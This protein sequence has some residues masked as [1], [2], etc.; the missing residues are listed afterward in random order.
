MEGTAQREAQIPSRAGVCA[1][2]AAAVHSSRQVKYAVAKDGSTR[3]ISWAWRVV[4]DELY[5]VAVFVPHEKAC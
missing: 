5:F 2:G 4:V 3:V 1:E